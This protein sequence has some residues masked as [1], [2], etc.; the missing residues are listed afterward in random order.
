MVKGEFCTNPADLTDMSEQPA[1]WAA[2]ARVAEIW[3]VTLANL[4]VVTRCVEVEFPLDFPKVV[5]HIVDH[6]PGE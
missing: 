4:V 2:A 5:V 6:S 1:I 3:L